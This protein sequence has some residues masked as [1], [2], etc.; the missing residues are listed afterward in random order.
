MEVRDAVGVAGGVIVPDSDGEGRVTE[1]DNDSD[2]L[3]C[4]NRVIVVIEAVPVTVHDAV[5]GG[6]RVAVCVGFESDNVG[7]I[8]GVI[9]SD[10]V[11]TE[12]ELLRV[13]VGVKAVAV[14]WPTQQKRTKST[15]TRRSGATTIVLKCDCRRCMDE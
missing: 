5:G 1:S 7:V 11:V 2:G 3:I 6:V 10:I 9:V 14:V 4:V 15:K 8:G 12:R 13:G